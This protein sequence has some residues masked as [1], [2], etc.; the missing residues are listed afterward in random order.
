MKWV[1]PATRLCVHHTGS[2]VAHDMVPFLGQSS[3][4]ANVRRLRN[5]CTM[6]RESPE[7]FRHLIMRKGMGCP[8]MFDTPAVV[9]KVTGVVGA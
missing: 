4:E 2:A 9:D 5:H 7:S 1:D 3:F 8:S 6:Y